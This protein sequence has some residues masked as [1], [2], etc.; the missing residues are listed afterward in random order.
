MNGEAVDEKMPI[1]FLDV[2]VALIWCYIVGSVG[3]V[4]L[5]GCFF[6]TRYDHRNEEIKAEARVGQ[7]P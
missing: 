7:M 3:A 5:Y 2:L 4:T 6:V 1:E